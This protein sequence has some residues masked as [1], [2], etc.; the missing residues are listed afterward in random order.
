MTPAEAQVL[1]S[2]AAA[3]D[4]R[5]PDT[6]TAKAWAAMLD[7]LRFEDCRV[8]IIEHFQ[9]STEY[10]MPAMVR[11]SVRRIRNKRLAVAGD[12]TPP[13]GLTQAEERAW[14]GQARRAIGDG[15]PVDQV[16]PALPTGRHNIAEL[17]QV[18]RDA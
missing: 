18:G 7:G 16:I 5:K 6:D 12:L 2:M 11:A 17:G 1:L 9:T 4:N 15:V 3:V 14:L 13:A 10:L 8:A